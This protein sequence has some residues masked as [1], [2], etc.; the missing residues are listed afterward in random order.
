MILTYI[1]YSHNQQHPEVSPNELAFH[2]GR[3]TGHDHFRIHRALLSMNPQLTFLDGSPCLTPADAAIVL[4]KAED[5][6]IAGAGVSLLREG[7]APYQL[8]A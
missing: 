5:E 3:A 2:L 8:A 7:A 4:S 1:D 6:L